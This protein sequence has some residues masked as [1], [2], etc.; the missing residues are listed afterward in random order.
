MQFL[1]G[2]IPLKRWARSLALLIAGTWINNWGVGYLPI[3][4]FGLTSAEES[5]AYRGVSTVVTVVM[6]YF[7]APGSWRRLLP[8]VKIGRWLSSFGVLAFLVASSGAI[9]SLSHH[10]F[11]DIFLATL[12]AF[13]IGI[14]ED[15][16]ARGFAF[17]VLEKHGVWIAAIISSVEF[18]AMHLFNLRAGYSWAYTSGQVVSAASFGFLCCGLMLYTGS[19]WAPIIFHAASDLPMSL[20]TSAQFTKDVTGGTD[21]FGV[22]VISGIYIAFGVGLIWADK[23]DFT[24]KKLDQYL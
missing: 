6:I 20:Q 19:I 11:F 9:H 22:L 3:R 12:W 2:E 7:F 23:K 10:S 5:F 18:G 4:N 17:G 21:W 14:E 15:T 13:S 16:F 8:A 24:L 1:W